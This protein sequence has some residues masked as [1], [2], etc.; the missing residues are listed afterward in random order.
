MN[1]I[2]AGIEQRAT[3]LAGI[4]TVVSFCVTNGTATVV[5]DVACTLPEDLSDADTVLAVKA[6]LGE[7][8]VQELENLVTIR[9][10]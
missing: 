3:E 10:A 7:Q 1:W 5:N 4:I 2:I 9:S 6:A 8:R